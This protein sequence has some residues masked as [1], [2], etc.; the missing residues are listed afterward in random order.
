LFIQNF[1]F[2]LSQFFRRRQWATLSGHV[3]LWADASKTVAKVKVVMIQNGSQQTETTQSDRS[4]IF[5]AEA[6]GEIRLRANKTLDDK[7]AA[8]VD[9]SDIVQ[10]RKYIL[11]RERLSSFLSMMAADPNRDDSIDVSDILDMRKLILVRT[12]YY[13]QDASGQPESLWRFFDSEVVT[14]SNQK[15][16]VKSGPL[17]KLTLS[18][19]TDSLS[20]LVFTGVK[21]GDVNGD[22]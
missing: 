7:V 11:A 4:L 15:D 1:S 12:T 18:P 5:D 6:S 9:V 17:E 14:A 19:A 16:L 3:Y 22:L 20:N 8:G 10:M 13:T 21:L 2:N